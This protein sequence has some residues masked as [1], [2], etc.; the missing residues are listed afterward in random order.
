MNNNLLNDK[1]APS[2]KFTEGSCF[3]F[4]NLFKIA[5]EYNKNNSDKINLNNMK[6]KKI[7]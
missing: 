4:T 3:T 6:K 5:E 7:Y 1:C 2:K